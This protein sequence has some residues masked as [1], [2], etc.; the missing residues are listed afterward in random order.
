M[1]KENG[2]VRLTLF[3]QSWLYF[4]QVLSMVDQ[5]TASQLYVRRQRP[6]SSGND[7]ASQQNANVFKTNKV[8]STPLR[9]SRRLTG[10]SW[11]R[12]D[13]AEVRRR[14]RRGPGTRRRLSPAA[15]S[16][17]DCTTWS[18]LALCP[19]WTWSAEKTTTTTTTTGGL[20]AQR[21][22]RWVCPGLWNRPTP[23][24]GWM[25]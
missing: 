24:P 18:C 6:R 4:T 14:D 7:S 5:C 20:M 3:L 8:R 11:G 15:S 21:L 2:N 17:Y 16:L 25:A 12:T 10:S 22:E 23:F 19:P 1:L 13:C 9:S